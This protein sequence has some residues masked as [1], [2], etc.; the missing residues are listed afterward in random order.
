MADDVAAPEEDVRKLDL[1]VMEFVQIDGRFR[2]LPREVDKGATLGDYHSPL[3]EGWQLKESSSHP[4]KFYYIQ[5]SGQA[6]WVPPLVKTGHLYAWRLLIYIEF[7]PGKLGMNLRSIVQGPDIPWQQF[8]V[9]IHD[10]RKLA[11]G[12]PSPAE[13]YNWSVKPDRRIY[14]GFR[15]VE[16]Q[17][18]SIAGLSYSEVIE[19]ISQTPRPVTIGFCDIARGLKGD[20]A[21]DEEE[22]VELEPEE[23]NR[24]RLR[25]IES[26]DMKTLVATQ[27]RKEV[28]AMDATRLRFDEATAVAKGR[29]L[30]HEMRV[31]RMV[32]GNYAAEIARLVPEKDRLQE[33]LDRLE[34]ERRRTIEPVELTRCQGIGARQE[35]LL[36]TIEHLGEENRRLQDDHA[37]R[38]AELDRLYLALD[39]DAA[40]G[41]ARLSSSQLLDE[42]NITG[43]PQLKVD[44]CHMLLFQLQ[45]ALQQEQDKA[46]LAQEEV[47]QLSRHLD[48]MNSRESAVASAAAR[49][50]AILGGRDESSVRD[51]EMKLEWL[52]HQLHKTGATLAKAE[53]RGNEKVAKAAQRR[54]ALL[55]AEVQVVHDELA[56]KRQARGPQPSCSTEAA[57]LGRKR[58]YL[59]TALVCV[60]VGATLMSHDTVA[61]IATTTANDDRAMYLA[62]R[63]FL[64]KELQS[65]EERLQELVHT[66]ALGGR[67]SSNILGT[68]PRTDAAADDSDDDD[69]YDA[70]DFRTSAFVDS[71]DAPGTPVHFAE[72]LSPVGESPVPS[73]RPPAASTPPLL[74]PPDH[75]FVARLSEAL[76][77]VR[78][79]QRLSLNSLDDEQARTDRA[80]P[81]PAKEPEPL[82]WEAEH[83]EPV[84]WQAET[85]ER[86]RQGEEERDRRE[87]EDRITESIRSLHD[88]DSDDDDG[89]GA[90]RIEALKKQLRAV[91][92]QLA[93]KPADPSV[94]SRLLR[95]RSRLKMELAAAQDAAHVDGLQQELHAAVSQ[96]TQAATRGDRAQETHWKRRGAELQQELVAATDRRKHAT[97][98]PPSLDELKNDLRAVVQQI[99]A[100]PPET[101]AMAE[102]LARKH[103]LKK[104]IVGKQQEI[105]RER[106]KR[107]E[108]LSL[109]ELK[110]QLKH[111]VVA[112]SKD[113]DNLMLQQR[114]KH[115]KQRIAKLQDRALAPSHG[116]RSESG[117]ADSA[118]TDYLQQRAHLNATEL[119]LD[120]RA[121]LNATE[122]LARPD[123]DA[124]DPRAARRRLA[125]TELV[126]SNAPTA[127]KRRS[128]SV[129]SRG[130]SSVSSVSRGVSSVSSV[131]RG[132][133]SANSYD[134]PADYAVL[135]LDQLERE[136]RLVQEAMRQHPKDSLAMDRLRRQQAELTA[137]IAR[138]EADTKRGSSALRVNLQELKAQLKA[139]GLRLEGTSHEKTF[140]ALLQQRAELKT[141]IARLEQQLVPEMPPAPAPLHPHASAA[142]IA[143]Y[144]SGRK[145][146]LRDVVHKLMAAADEKDSVS[147]SHYMA[148]RKELKAAILA[149]QEALARS[150][151]P[152]A[153]GGSRLPSEELDAPAVQQ[154]IDGLKQELRDI[155]VAVAHA[156]AEKPELLRRR[157]VVK[158]QLA[159]AQDQHAHLTSPEVAETTKEIAVVEQYIASLQDD[160]AAVVAQINA[161]ADRAKAALLMMRRNDL[162]T[163]LTF[164]QDQLVELRQKLKAARA[165]APPLR[166]SAASSGASSADAAKAE[167]PP[168]SDEALVRLT[169]TYVNVPMQAGYLELEPQ[170]LKRFRKGKVVWASL[171]ASGCLCWYASHRSTKHVRGVVD[172]AKTSSRDVAV[173]YT[174]GAASFVVT[175]VRPGLLAHAEEHSQFVAPSAAEARQWVRALRD[176]IA[177]LETAQ[178]AG[179][180]GFG[181][182]SVVF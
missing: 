117:S 93:A 135:S 71:P 29:V 148:R 156:P 91:M 84:P 120:D 66:E 128:N 18:T 166:Q 165:K 121:R 48:A 9:E 46:Q 69:E 173:A 80:P 146:E 133:S 109:D 83:Q 3:P 5:P 45:E 51:L 17:G 108:G 104:Q 94:A 168:V 144:I 64:K 177:L 124:D 27:L 13:M 132:V 149:A 81:S 113:P 15:M 103:E 160:L 86:R 61:K 73:P 172:L 68:P 158:E 78:D 137:R 36:A 7:G 57:L 49:A 52:R 16:I 102:L 42:Y 147:S 34:L 125:G 161:P 126:A 178:P 32:S 30:K 111:V 155:V 47:N 54:R 180:D 92:A 179:A 10:L 174:A 123:D 141:Q 1:K 77:V 33:Q 65:T 105:L 171:E 11:S 95:E 106:A 140:R 56:A 28:W 60:D 31:L 97:P 53:K 169:Q 6:Q 75:A 62:R 112:M 21:D 35:E 99:A 131:S 41:A 59:R 72:S 67:R 55:K 110:T 129:E 138:A 14:P 44:Y 136:L 70:N 119:L 90:H 151:A 38:T 43:P 23:E 154:H 101:R 89:R 163:N 58:T 118:S 134:T 182:N 114:R 107:D 164:A 63:A 145:A 159:A 22:D 40:P 85:P 76:A 87:S 176:T 142:E 127:P 26:E 153:G 157:S 139:V 82:R 162:K 181:R 74:P 2:A 130:V 50:D 115:I 37:T 116:Q 19:K 175:V 170:A 24:L 25:A 122:L 150:S 8:Q 167:E 100:T 12:L 79:S 20:P 98:P 143:M 88:N 96:A 39:G 152:D 4:G